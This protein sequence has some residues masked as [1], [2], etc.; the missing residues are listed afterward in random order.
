MFT[1][2]GASGRTL[3]RYPTQIVLSLLLALS[4]VP[5]I[6]Q[7][8]RISCAN[9]A[10]VPDPEPAAL[11]RDCEVLINDIEFQ[12]FGPS[13]QRGHYGGWGRD[14]PMSQW[15]YISVSSGRV[16]RVN[17]ADR[18]FSSAAIP[19]GMGN[20]TGLQYLLLG[21]NYGLPADGDG[22]LGGRERGDGPDG[23]AELHRRELKDGAGGDGGGRRGG[24]HAGPLRVFDSVRWMPMQESYKHGARTKSVNHG[25]RT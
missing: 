20:L 12:L 9:S 7:N 8:N 23:L 18:N 13:Y 11:V 16:T 4:A 14:T 21:G 10:A 17:I 5:A 25:G 19:I 1:P 15:G 24:Q 3:L 2:N 22:G 6:A